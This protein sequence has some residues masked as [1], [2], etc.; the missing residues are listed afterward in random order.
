MCDTEALRE[1]P[2]LPPI[3][4][5][6]EERDIGRARRRERERRRVR[7]RGEERKKTRERGRER[8]T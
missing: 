5:A 7:N 8:K 1:A 3:L 6:R 4:T 2:Q